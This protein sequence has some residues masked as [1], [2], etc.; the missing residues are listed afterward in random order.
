M[1]AQPRAS[2]KAKPE[3][4]VVKSEEL[5]PIKNPKVIYGLPGGGFVDPNGFPVTADGEPITESAE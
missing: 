4:V 1:S 2:A 5:Q 3:I